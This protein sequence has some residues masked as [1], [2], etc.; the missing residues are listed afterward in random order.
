MGR[1]LPEYLV[2]YA[3]SSRSK[4]KSCEEIIKEGSLRI[5]KRERSD[6]FDG[7]IHEWRHVKCFF[8]KFSIASDEL[9]GLG[10]MK[11]N[12]QVSLKK[13][14]TDGGDDAGGEEAKGSGKKRKASEQLMSEDQKRAKKEADEMWKQRTKL[15]K[16]YKNDQLRAILSLT[17]QSTKG[18]PDE[19]LSRVVDCKILGGLPACPECENTAL[20][21]QGEKIICQGSSSEWSA[22]TFTCPRDDPK[23][24]RQKW[25]MPKDDDIDDEVQEYK[26][27]KA[28]AKA[29]EKE[30]IAAALGQSSSSSSQS[31]GRSTLKYEIMSVRELKAELKARELL[32]SGTKDELIERL[33]EDDGSEE[34]ESDEEEDSSEEESE[35]E[36]DKPINKMTVKALREELEERGLETKGLKAT[37][38]KRLEEHVE[39]NREA[40]REE[41]KKEKEKKAKKGD[42]EE[43][44]VKEET[45]AAA[46][47]TKKANVDKGSG[48]TDDNA[49]VVTNAAGSPFSVTLTKSDMEVGS[50]GMNSFYKQQLIKLSKSKCIVY[51]KW[52]RVGEEGKDTTK[53]FPSLEKAMAFFVKNFYEKTGNAWSAY[54]NADFKKKSGRFFPVEIE[55]GDGGA[56]DAPLGRL[57]KE[58]IELGQKVLE[59]IDAELNGDKRAIKLKDMSSEFFSKIPTDFGGEKPKPID[60]IEL[61]HEKEELLKFYLRMGFEDMNTDTKDLTPISGVMDLPVPKTLWD[62]AKSV[63]NKFEV[64][65][66]VNTGAQFEARQAGGPTKYMNKELY[67]SILLYTS[68]AIYADLNKSLRE[69]NR[70]KV[71]RYFSYL[72]LFFEA[73]DFLPKQNAHLWRGISCCLYDQY[74]VGKVITWWGVSSCT[75]DQSVARNFMNSC[76]GNCSFLTVKA[77]TAC[78]ISNLTF[79]SNEKESLLAPGTQLKVLKSKKVGKVAEIELEEVGRAFG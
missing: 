48:F 53:E 72:R 30:E 65:N 43:K 55:E 1:V 19:V 32:Q 14:C 74:Q 11:W 61:L 18:S 68:N 27:K 66:S 50:V 62:A 52:G 7:D 71:S 59:R 2:Q 5:G 60:T 56:G 8:A 38:V 58:Q 15:S 44:P 17:E 64:D 47:S 57:T 29:R 22:C 67:A 42:K 49:E 34:E 70:K 3:K 51:C 35:D 78:D 12:D 79:Y 9:T 54:E 33:Q 76:G 39:E 25:K 10:E 6:R 16:E 40:R 23:V 41:R 13:K 28:E 46:R 31:P 24:K 26:L 4:C 73:M 20:T 75:S 77:K 36:F 21:R 63:T 45:R 37:L 69:E